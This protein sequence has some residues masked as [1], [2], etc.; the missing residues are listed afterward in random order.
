MISRIDWTAK[1][2]LLL[3]SAWVKLLPQ[4]L[5]EGVDTMFVYN[6]MVAC[7]ARVNVGYADGFR[8]VRWK[9]VPATV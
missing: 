5:R 9:E 6:G 4:Q 2:F 7:K 1:A 3:Q 8:M